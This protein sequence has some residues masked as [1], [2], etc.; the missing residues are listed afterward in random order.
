M[1]MG[2]DEPIAGED[3][4]EIAWKWSEIHSATVNIRPARW[5]Y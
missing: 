3:I 1:T 2:G 4:A 5:D